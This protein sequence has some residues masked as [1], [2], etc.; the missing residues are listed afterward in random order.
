MGIIMP[1]RTSGFSYALNDDLKDKDYSVSA[2]FFSIE[3][4]PVQEGLTLV[5]E[6][7]ALDRKGYGVVGG[8]V[9]NGAD[10]NATQVKIVCAI[11]NREGNVIDSIFDYT[12]PDTIPA[13]Q[14]ARFNIFTHYRVSQE[15]TTSCNAESI[16]LAIEEV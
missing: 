9:F 6:E 15:F 11:Y 8:H 16:E 12:D 10:H 1:N 3:E 2:T 4:K 13:G 5:V 7:S 14:D